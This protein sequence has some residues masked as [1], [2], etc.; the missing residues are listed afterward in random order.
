MK[1][2]GL[3]KEQNMKGGCQRGLFLDRV[4]K[5]ALLERGFWRG[6]LNDDLEERH[7]RQGRQE[8]GRLWNRG[9]HLRKR[10]RCWWME[11]AGKGQTLYS[12]SQGFVEWN[13]KRLQTVLE[14]HMINVLN[15]SLSY[16]LKGC[17]KDLQILQR[18]QLI[19]G[20]GI[21]WHKKA[22]EELPL[23]LEL[24][25]NYSEQRWQKAEGSRG[26]PLTSCFNYEKLLLLISVR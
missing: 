13:E 25:W 3:A 5:K 26:Q 24:G 22:G 1:K 9:A 20:K 19:Q 11:E 14:Q 10:K 17:G 6:D 2:L 15:R 12:P 4:W 16:S 18:W 23:F 21:W 7:P 8:M